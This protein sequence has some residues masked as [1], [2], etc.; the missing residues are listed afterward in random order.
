MLRF[1]FSTV[2]LILAFVPSLLFAQQSGPG[3]VWSAS[4]NLNTQNGCPEDTW[5]FDVKEAAGGEFVLAGYVEGNFG[6]G[7]CGDDDN[8]VPGYAVVS[9]D[10]ELV[11]SGYFSTG[12]GQFGKIKRVSD[13]FI[14]AGHQNVLVGQNFVR[15]SFLVKLNNDFSVCWKSW[16]DA[17]GD[18]FVNAVDVFTD[19]DG[20]T[21]IVVTAGDNVAKCVVSDAT[22]N[23][24]F[25]LESRLS[26]RSHRPDLGHE[27]SAGG[28]ADTHHFHRR[29][30]S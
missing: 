17:P 5:S 21:N 1:K 22:C 23:P 3:A 30:T 13:G 28:R 4:V 10:G 24:A 6:F 7:D 25:T 14:L 12:F 8:R 27:I 20:K 29:S 2:L 16:Y 19:S 9:K 11:T 26:V 18:E 15:H